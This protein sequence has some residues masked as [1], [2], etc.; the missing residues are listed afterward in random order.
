VDGDRRRRGLPLAREQ[1][2][3]HGRPGAERPIVGS[4]RPERA[5]LLAGRL[6]RR[7]LRLRRRQ[8]LRFDGRHAP[9][10]PDRRDRPDPS[11]LGYWLVASDGGIFAFATPTST[12]R[13]RTHLNQPVVG[14]APAPS[15]LGY[16]LV[17]SDG[18][19]FAFGDANFY[20][21]MGAQHLNQPIVG[22]R[23]RPAVMATGWW[24]GTGASSTSGAPPSPALRSDHRCGSGG[25]RRRRSRFGRLL[26]RH[27]TG[28][29]SLRRATGR[30]ADRWTDNRHLD[31]RRGGLS[32]GS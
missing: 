25:G 23:L 19:I 28:G 18:G 32:A 20:G 27:R 9:Q 10:R 16:W 5:R 1:R 12:V 4:R 29:S 15:G 2:R 31:Q 17:A 30:L 22:W 7:D 24:R 13:W 8:L 21:S 3:L 14:I 26:G 11:G 6:R